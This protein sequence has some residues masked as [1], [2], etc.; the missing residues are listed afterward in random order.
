MRLSLMLTIVCALLVTASTEFGIEGGVLIPTGDESDAYN[1][2]PML[3]L[4]I[5]FHIP[6]TYGRSE[7]ENL[8]TNR[9][10]SDQEYK[11]SIEFRTGFAFIN[12]ELNDYEEEF[13]G[14]FS[15]HMV[16]VMLGMRSYVDNLF[17]GGGLAY[18]FSYWSNNYD[19]DSEGNLGM[20][21]TFGTSIP[22]RSSRIE[23]SGQLH[24]I[25]FTDLWL[26]LTAGAY[27]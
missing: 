2:S 12:L 6:S 8:W 3:G 10:Y 26:G 20:Y 4:G 11:Y 1:I 9:G 27:L 25:D 16:P 15:R 17:F 19:D 13:G 24:F 14:E 18:H 7:E 22:T 23:L 5:L 21:G